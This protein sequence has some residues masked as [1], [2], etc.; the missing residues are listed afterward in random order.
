MSQGTEARLS[1]VLERSQEGY[2]TAIETA[3]EIAAL[4]YLMIGCARTEEY[5]DP[6]VPI[7][8]ANFPE[9]VVF[10][11]AVPPD[12][13]WGALVVNER[14]GIVPV[15]RAGNEPSTTL[16]SAFGGDV[17][18]PRD[19]ARL[20]REILPT[21]IVY[22][23][24][25]YLWRYDTGVGA[26]VLGSHRDLLH[27]LAPMA[28]DKVIG[29]GDVVMPQQNMVPVEHEPNHFGLREQAPTIGSFPVRVRDVRDLP[30]RSFYYDPYDPTTP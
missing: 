4:G 15:V 10:S 17:N 23:L 14:G 5:R 27:A 30:I 7:S 26:Y 24:G 18:V 16:F 22:D 3:A 2:I 11:G 12:A 29:K 25:T 20:G 1:D 8:N 21:E 13:D 19:R 28:P 9:D 6:G